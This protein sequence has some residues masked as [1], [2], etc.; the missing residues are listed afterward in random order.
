MIF[1]VKIDGITVNR[2]TLNIDHVEVE[3]EEDFC[4]IHF[5]SGEKVKYNTSLKTFVKK[6]GTPDGLISAHRKYII[7][8][9]E[10]KRII[11]YCLIK[12]NYAK[13]LEL[14]RK[15][16]HIVKEYLTQKLKTT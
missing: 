1:Q 14:G 15:A 6:Y 8:L 11:K 2:D 7:N 13:P 3:A 12:T 16:Y 9:P 10:V 4:W 5:K